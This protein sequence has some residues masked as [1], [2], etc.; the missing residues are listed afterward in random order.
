VTCFNRFVMT[1]RIVIAA[2]AIVICAGSARADDPVPVASLAPRTHFH[3][4]AVDLADSKRLY[5]ATHHGLYAVSLDGTAQRISD[6]TND[7]MGFTPHPSDPRVLFASGH[8]PQGGNLG[9]M[10]S[11][12]AGRTWT[13]IADGVNGPVDFHHM[14]VSKSDPKVVYGVFRG[15]QRS[16]DGGRT[17][18]LVGPAPEGMIDLA[19]SSRDVNTLYAA[20]QKGLL[21]STDGG[22]NWKP[23]HTLA[24]PATLV[25]TTRDGEAYTFIAGLGLLRA[26]EDALAWAKVSDGFGDS[27]VVHLA[28]D[29]KDARRIYVVTLDPKSQ[30]PALLA[31]RDGGASWTALGLQ[32]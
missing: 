23:A 15:L 27:Y 26:K 29:P 7:T 17:W 21:R 32:R 12:D 18:A 11:T 9:F 31:T 16:D 19:V 14:D 30:L 13:K 4:L 2:A 22:R 10:E 8:P 28:V 5:L 24:R 1:T 6:T 20:T 3:G 25:R